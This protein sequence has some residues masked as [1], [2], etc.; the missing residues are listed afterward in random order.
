[1][2]L[3]FNMLTVILSKFLCV[4][5]FLLLARPG[6]ELEI[7]LVRPDLELVPGVRAMDLSVPALHLKAS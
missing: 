6:V 1:M 3:L 7:A 5:D 4:G 2:A